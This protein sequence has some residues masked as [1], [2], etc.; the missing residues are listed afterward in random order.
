M[1]G[2]G[3]LV[4]SLSAEVTPEQTAVRLVRAKLGGAQ[5]RGAA[6]AVPNCWS[7]AAIGQFAKVSFGLRLREA[8]LKISPLVGAGWLGHE[9]AVAGD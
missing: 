3:P 9:L 5:V 2:S 6:Q 8:G 7:G 4:A 1:L